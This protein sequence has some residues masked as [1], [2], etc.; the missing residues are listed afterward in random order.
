MELAAQTLNRM[1]TGSEDVAPRVVLTCNPNQ[2]MADRNINAY[3]NTSCF[4]PAGVGSVAD[5][6]GINRLRGPGGNQWDMSLYKRINVTEKAYAQ[7]RL[8]AFNAMNHPQFASYNSTI[9]FN[10]A[11]QVI[12]LPSQLGGTGGRFGL[13]ALN[14]TRANSNRI[15]QVAVKFYF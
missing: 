10:S 8:E 2:S 9:V 6:S 13:G 3:I 5:D 14:A 1:I 11:G 15:L 4:A 7:L 12:N